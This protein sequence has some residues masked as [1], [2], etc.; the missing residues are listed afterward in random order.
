MMYR[1]EYIYQG[2]GEK[3][4]R[5]IDLKMSQYRVTPLTVNNDPLKQI[6][7]RWPKYE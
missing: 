4:D 7:N 5:A 2:Q 1:R 3:G 6:N